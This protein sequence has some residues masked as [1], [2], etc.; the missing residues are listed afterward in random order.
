MFLNIFLSNNWSLFR[1][2]TVTLSPISVI[3]QCFTFDLIPTITVIFQKDFFLFWCIKPIIEYSFLHRLAQIRERGI[4][5]K[6]HQ[7]YAVLK[8]A[9]EQPST[10]DVS[11]VTV[12][13]ILVVLV[14]GYLIG[15]FVLLIERCVHGNILICWP[16]GS[17]RKCLQNEYWRLLYN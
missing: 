8:E 12:A 14:A 7:Q 4:Q 9:E 3:H 6:I 16:R 13:P 1:Y 2:L 17:V 11:M 5:E 15:I 10:I